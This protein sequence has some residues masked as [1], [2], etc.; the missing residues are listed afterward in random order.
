MNGIY[1]LANDRV[2]ELV[3]PFLNSVRTVEPTRPLCLIPFDD[4]Y[5]EIEGFAKTYNFT[6]W[7][8][9]YALARCDAI[10]RRF[11]KSVTGQYRKLVAWEGPF[12]EFAYIDVDTIL[13]A[14][15]DRVFPLLSKYDAITGTSNMESI[16]RFVWRDNA[17]SVFPGLDTTYSANTGFVLSKRGVL[18]LQD[19]EKK[20]NLAQP[21]KEYMALECTEQP[22]LNYLLVTSGRR[23]TSL[24]EIR[25][26]HGRAA[27]SEQ[28][29]PG[30]V[31]GGRF[32]EVLHGKGSSTLF[33]H[34]A[35]IW[36]EGANRRNDRWRHFRYMRDESHPEGE[37]GSEN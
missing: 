10:S 18:T 16:K 34:W 33:V 2:R 32:D 7:S 5:H 15:L 37:G 8:D 29:I 17:E 31:W 27:S 22:F 11:H 35:G 3:I 9:A 25:K 12:E 28:E 20:A 21:F 26:K 14:S 19:A 6:I 1:F 30:E 36:R 23:Y 13:L 4:D 24:S